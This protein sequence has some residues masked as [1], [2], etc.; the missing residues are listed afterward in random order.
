MKLGLL[1]PTRDGQ[2]YGNTE[3]SKDSDVCKQGDGLDFI[4][5]GRSAAVVL[6]KKDHIIKRPLLTRRVLFQ[7]D[8]A[9]IHTAIV[10]SH[11]HQ[12]F[13]IKCTASAIMQSSATSVTRA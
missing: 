12:W 1:I 11:V 3:E 4:D 13:L 10:A 6:P 2:S 7:Q 9:L 8:S 5:C